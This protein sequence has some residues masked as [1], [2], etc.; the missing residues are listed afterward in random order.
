MDD[1]AFR[2]RLLPGERIIWTGRP[3][4]GVI[5]TGRDVF[6]IPFSLVWCSFAIFWTVMATAGTV[7]TGHAELAWFPLFG[8]AFVGVGLYFVAGRFVVDAW[9][10]SAIRYALTDRRVLILRSGPFS[11]FTALTLERLPD[12]K[13]SDGRKGRGTIRFGQSASPWGRGFGGWSPAFDSTPQFLAV[14]DARNVFDL[15]Q[16]SASRAGLASN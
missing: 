11:D 13:L 7:G 12:T 15:I 9:I 8:V 2:G 14:P 3:A 4:R 10:R 6:L 5:F 1:E 16:R